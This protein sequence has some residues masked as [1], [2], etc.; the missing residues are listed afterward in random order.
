M[1]NNASDIAHL[2]L[3]GGGHAQIFVLESLAMAPIEG[4][5]VT[6][7][8]QDILTPY[9]GMLPGFIEGKYTA[10]ESM[11]DLA[12]L[13]KYAGVH[14]IHAQAVGLNADEKKVFFKDRPPLS[15][16]WLSVNTG[17]SPAIDA[18]EGAAQ[19][20]TPVK[21]VPQLISRITPIID[22]HLKKQS[23]TIIGGGIAGT[24]V[25]LA[26]NHRLNIERQTETSITL[27]HLGERLADEFT[28]RASS[29]LLKACQDRNIKVLLNAPARLIT[30]SDVILDNHD[31]V[32][33]DMTLLA[34]G[35][36]APSWFA[37]SGLAT[38]ARGF[39]A[40]ND[41]LMSLSH[42]SVFAAGDIAGIMSEPRAKA[43]VFAVRAGPVLAR[44]LRREILEQSAKQWTPQHK[45]LALIGTGGGKAIPIRGNIAL[46]ESR[47]AWRLKESIDRRFIRRFSD[48]T[49]MPDA[50]LAPLAQRFHTP[51]DSAFKPMQCFG[52]GSKTGWKT[53]ASTLDDSFLLADTLR[54]DLKIGKFKRSINEDAADL[55]MPKDAENH[56]LVQS[57]DQI[58]AIIDDAFLLGRIATLHALSD[59]FASHAK[60][61]AAQIIITLPRAARTIQRDDLT[62]VLTGILIALTEHGAVLTGGHTTIGDAL[63]IGVAATGLRKKDLKTQLPAKGDALIL[64]KPLGVGLTM[65]AYHQRRN[66]DIGEMVEKATKVMAQSNHA[67]AQILGKHASTTMTDITGFG[68]LRHCRSMLDR[69]KIDGTEHLSATINF[70]NIPMIEGTANLAAQG[71]LSSITPDNMAAVD[72]LDETTEGNAVAILNDPQTSGGL[73]AA[74]PAR[75][76]SKA[77]DDLRRG[78]IEAAIIGEISDSTGGLIKVS[79]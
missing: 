18:I 22:N 19:H 74:M 73:L 21:P 32:A 59:L 71:I 8:C 13:A 3:L 36:S 31:P 63:H 67:A 12:H 27:I 66:L 44:N 76:A 11:V 1:K 54:P 43:G 64:T 79:D 53:L 62:Q 60:P 61:L 35:A 77:L 56:V 55:E 9:S 24:E 75:Y 57:V 14:F 45:Y 52:C 29:L 16:D 10:R 33:S 20:A 17:S 50:P 69:G 58:S 70:S 25:A 7:V 15:Y 78:G 5:R 48:L 28:P 34:T 30:E 23:L 42:N 40:V 72:F 37:S 47:W 46:P 38:D 65:A 51:D 4:L 49:P 26:L 68:L 39:I 6:L 2:V 41:T